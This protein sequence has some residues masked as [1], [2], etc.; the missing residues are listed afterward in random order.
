MNNNETIGEVRKV[1]TAVR[2]RLERRVRIR[3]IACAAILVTGAAHA[4]STGVRSDWDATLGAG[5]AIA[6]RYPGSDARR[7][8]P[9]PLI[10]VHYGRWFIGNVP[11]FA[12][13]FGLGIDLYRDGNWRFGL[14]ASSTLRGTRNESDDARLAGLG[15]IG[16]PLR[17]GAFGAYSARCF[18]VRGYVGTD[19]SRS[20]Q[21][22][23]ATLESELRWQPVDRLTLTTGPGLMW[24]NGRYAQT[25]YGIDATQSARSGLPAYH[26]GAGIG[27]A[28]WLAGARWRIDNHWQLTASAAIER[29]AGDARDSPVVRKSVQTYF[30]VG[31]AYRF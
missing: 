3:Y 4:Q 22:T 19:L 30:M 6:P 28:Y 15:D 18:E 13:P 23:I 31:T 14:A 16:R 29:L 27:A 8:S 12:N 26:A 9:V 10:D 7:V 1:E 21:G 17:L 5:V 2:A 20:R 25:L 24:T 11:S